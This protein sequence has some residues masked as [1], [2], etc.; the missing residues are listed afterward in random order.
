MELGGWLMSIVG[1]R[2]CPQCGGDS[3]HIVYGLPAPDA[4]EAEER[5]EIRLG[6]CCVDGDSPDRECTRCGFRWRSEAAGS[7]FGL[8]S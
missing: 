1:S 2:H 3:L 6:G 8:R 7:P 4:F 5:G